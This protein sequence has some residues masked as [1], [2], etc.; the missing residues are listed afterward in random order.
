M[1]LRFR[2]QECGK[3]LQV[4]ENPG[5][6]VQC[7]YCRQVVTVPFGAVAVAPGHAPSPTLSE[8]PSGDAADLPPA[9]RGGRVLAFVA[10]YLPSWGTSAVCHLAILLVALVTCSAMAPP[11]ERV[12]VESD[13]QQVSHPRYVQPDQG[14]SKSILRPTT[15]TDGGLA[16]RRSTSPVFQGISDI[17]RPTM[18]LEVIGLGDPGG[19]SSCFVPGGFNRGHGSPDDANAIFRPLGQNG[20]RRV[21]YI[22]DR[23]GS[24][25]DSFTY[26]KHEMKR[27]IRSLRPSD[28]FFVVFYSSG[29]AVEMPVRKMVPATEANK[30]QAYEFID[31]IVASGQTDPSEA[32]RRTFEVGANAVYLLTDGEFDPGIAGLIDRL[33][34]RKDVT[35][36]TIC[37]IYED[38][39]PLL[40]EI[41]AHNGGTYRYVAEQDL[42]KIQAEGR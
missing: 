10:T 24:M 3:R 32:L 9:T 16:F 33:N 35:I 20:P 39:G 42:S 18:N 37:F 41:A 14:L 19:Q 2:C 38:G 25:T 28:S 22:V 11:P 27:S 21:A 15:K 29:P 17:A 26:V 13:V 12:K 36:H 6:R 40:K 31:G 4:D 8:A 7:P 34:T 5:T 30:L 1:S 23:S